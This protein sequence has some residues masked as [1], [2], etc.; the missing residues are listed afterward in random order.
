MAKLN[1]T[2]INGKL[3]VTEDVNIGDM[4]VKEELSKLNSNL[5]DY[6]VEQGTSGIWTYRKWK[7]GIAECWGNKFV[8]F[9][10]KEAWGEVY[11]HSGCFPSVLYPF[12]FIDI[13]NVVASPI[14]NGWNFWLGTNDNLSGDIL[15]E[16]TPV[17]TA[18]RATNMN[19]IISS[20]GIAYFVIGKWK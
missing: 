3:D 11:T 20:A 7:S 14:V 13:P 5:S 15:K 6:I 1:D 10:A 4:S 16:K 19:D 2:S 17:F 12:A 9:N 18:I 8:S